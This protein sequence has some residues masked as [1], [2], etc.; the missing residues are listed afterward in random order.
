MERDRHPPFSYQI[1]G[2]LVLVPLM[3]GLFIIDE[4]LKNNGLLLVSV[5]TG[6]EQQGRGKGKRKKGVRHQMSQ[7]GRFLNIL[8]IVIAAKIELCTFNFLTDCSTYII[9]SISRR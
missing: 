7:F 9:V 5:V 3:W 6:G 4:A 8:S 2:S 1:D